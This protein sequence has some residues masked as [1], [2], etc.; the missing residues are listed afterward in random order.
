MQ[1]GMLEHGLQETGNLLLCDECAASVFAPENWDHAGG[2]VE[3]LQTT[4]P[5]EMRQAM[6]RANKASI[7]VVCRSHGMTPAEAKA[8]A[9]ELAIRWWDDPRMGAVEVSAF[10]KRSSVMAEIKALRDSQLPS[11]AEPLEPDNCDFCRRQITNPGESVV[12]LKGTEMLEQFESVTC[13]KHVSNHKDRND[14][15]QL[16]LACA[17]CGANYLKQQA[18]ESQQPPERDK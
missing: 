13:L 3:A 5:E 6:R 7:A 17:G 4:D 12:I 18:S 1:F 15:S 16:F 10:W 9:R 14:G 8:K 11:D 2:N